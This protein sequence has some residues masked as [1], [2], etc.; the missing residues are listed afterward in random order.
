MK[1]IIKINFPIPLSH[2]NF[3]TQP[4]FLLQTKALLHM[5][6]FPL[7]GHKNFCFLTLKPITIA[8]SFV[9]QVRVGNN[10]FHVMI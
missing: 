1:G 5:V 4:V 10:Y 9:G 6:R 7:W 2:P 3:A 8:S